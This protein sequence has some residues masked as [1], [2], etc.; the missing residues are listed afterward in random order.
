MVQG[1]PWLDSL[2]TNCSFPVVTTGLEKMNA[3]RGRDSLEVHSILSDALDEEE[4]N[5]SKPVIW[6]DCDRFDDFIRDEG[7]R[8]AQVMELAIFY[9]VDE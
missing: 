8:V 2:D 9:R 3:Q 1:F 5:T 7:W 6:D 4:Q